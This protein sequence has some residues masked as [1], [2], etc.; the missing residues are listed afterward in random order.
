F[1]NG[2]DFYT[3]QATF[4]TGDLTKEHVQQIADSMYNPLIQSAHIKSR[5]EF[6]QD[7]GMDIVIPRVKL[8]GIDKV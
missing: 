8:Q 5:K 6:E 7:H 2:E 4:I 3:S 1:D